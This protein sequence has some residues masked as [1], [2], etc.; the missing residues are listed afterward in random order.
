MSWADSRNSVPRCE[1][2]DANP[3]DIKGV[4]G[5]RSP[6]VWLRDAIRFVGGLLGF[7]EMAC[8]CVATA[9]M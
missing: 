8:E 6:L 1:S 7:Q 9:C 3:I 2:D 4:G 5:L